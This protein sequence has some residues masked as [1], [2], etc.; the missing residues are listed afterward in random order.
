MARSRLERRFIV[1]VSAMEGSF[2]R[3]YKSE[4]H[5]HTNMAKAALNM[6]TRTSAA[7]LAK[8][9]VFMTSVDTG[10]ITNEQPFP[11]RERMR[12]EFGFNP[13][14]DEVDGAARVL[15]PILRGVVEAEAP[16]GLF[17]KDYRAVPW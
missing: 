5:P 13:P 12:L 7:G 15:D 9:S 1:N 6:L 16:F 14:L 4:A 17:L 10:W 11:V 8:R 3:D 2:S